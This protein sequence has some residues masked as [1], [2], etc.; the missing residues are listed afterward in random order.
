M[1]PY[2][3]ASEAFGVTGIPRLFVVLPY[4]EIT[5]SMTGVDFRG[6]EEAVHERTD[7]F[8]RELAQELARAMRK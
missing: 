2:K 8:K 7:A 6:S 3:K 5:A 4:G 1:D